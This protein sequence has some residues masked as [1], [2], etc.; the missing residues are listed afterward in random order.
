M[1]FIMNGMLRVYDE[2]LDELLLKWE[3]LPNKRRG[4][5]GISHRIFSESRIDSIQ[6]FFAWFCI[7]TFHTFMLAASS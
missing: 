6:S 7:F 2:F 3:F 4:I 1:H 5:G